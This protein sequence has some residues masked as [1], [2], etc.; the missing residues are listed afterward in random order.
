MG[1][2]QTTCLRNIGLIYMCRKYMGEFVCLFL[3]EH[4]GQV[5]MEKGETSS[6]QHILF[7]AAAISHV[8]RN[9]CPELIIGEGKV[10]MRGKSG[11]PRMRRREEGV[12]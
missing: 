9:N 5:T 3:S 2:G 6:A 4:S 10:V 7:Q 1:D 8:H 12:I 11:Q